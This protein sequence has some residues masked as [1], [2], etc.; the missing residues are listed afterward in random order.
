MAANSM[1]VQSAMLIK[2]KTGVDQRGKD[3]IKTERFSKLRLDCTDDEILE[4]ANA[5]GQALKYP[6]AHLSRENEQ[7][8]MNA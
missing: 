4:V 8:I 5:M 2:Y 6:V 1:L 3:I 7:R